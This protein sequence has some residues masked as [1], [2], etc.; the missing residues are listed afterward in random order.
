MKNI[1]KFIITYFMMISV[2]AILL[3][4]P[5]NHVNR[6]ELSTEKVSDYAY[7]SKSDLA[8]RERP[9]KINN[10]INNILVQYGPEISEDENPKK[11]SIRKKPEE[12][13]EKKK[14]E[15]TEEITE[16]VKKK[17]KIWNAAYNNP[18]NFWGKVI[19]ENGDPIEGA[20]VELSVLDDP[21]W[22]FDGTS[23]STYKVKTDPQGRFELLGKKGASVYAVASQEGYAQYV[24]SKKGNLSSLSIQ[25]FEEENTNMRYKQPTED[26]PTTLILRKKN[27]IASLSHDSKGNVDISR[28][29]DTE[30]I[31]LKAKEKE[32]KIKIRC[33]SSAPVPFKYDQYDWRA[34]IEVVG[35]KLQPITKEAAIEAPEDGYEDLYKISMGKDMEP[36]DWKAANVRTD[37]F[38]IQLDDGTF[39]K[40]HIKIRTGRKHQVHV[41]VWHNPDGTTN[42]EQ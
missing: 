40:S 27:S 16:E 18:I 33:W 14:K 10:T 42:F 7:F 9:L 20:K 32:I 41:E 13:I 38:W 26:T 37:Q 30:E 34:E 1:Q 15:I 17:R 11:E 22:S 19:D 24:D 29:G 5:Q 23:S 21:S 2:T 28:T 4:F 31:L 12:I 36:K 39:A 8:S 25:Y 3:L 6:L 35:G